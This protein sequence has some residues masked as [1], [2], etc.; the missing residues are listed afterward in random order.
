MNDAIHT[1]RSHIIHL[2]QSVLDACSLTDIEALKTEARVILIDIGVVVG[3]LPK[4]SGAT[5][6]EDWKDL[7]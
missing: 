5:V 4:H 6:V 3:S 1:Y 7:L 2:C